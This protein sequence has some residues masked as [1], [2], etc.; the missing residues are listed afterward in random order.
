MFSLCTLWSHM[1]CVKIYLLRV[2]TSVLGRY[3]WLTGYPIRFTP[4]QIASSAQEPTEW[5]T[6]LVPE[7]VWSI[8][9]KQTISTLLGLETLFF[10]HPAHTLVATPTTLS[11]IPEF[12]RVLTWSLLNLSHHPWVRKV[13]SAYLSE[14]ENLLT[15]IFIH[16][17]GSTVSSFFL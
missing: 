3:E 8:C 11:H 13:P 9:R 4:G 14:A 1:V 16:S 2:F 12:S 10:S 15:D 17:A 5:E 6:V 7:P